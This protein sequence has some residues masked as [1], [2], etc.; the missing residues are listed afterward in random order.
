M[1]SRSE[2][3]EEAL[4]RFFE[5]SLDLMCIAGF[6]GIFKRINQTWTKVLGWTEKELTSAPY[7]DLVHPDDIE[8]TKSI[9]DQIAKGGEII[10]FENRY[11]CRDGSYRTLLWRATPDQECSLI[12]AVARDITE[13][14][15]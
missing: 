8:S 5:A 11:R 13:E 14:R 7:L 2:D 4:G 12:Y 15:L 10:H 3:S 6:D 9:A 1:K